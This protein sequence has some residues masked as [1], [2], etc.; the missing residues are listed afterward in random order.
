MT[1]MNRQVRR[2]LARTAAPDL[3]AVVA[4]AYQLLRAGQCQAAISAF[5][6]LLRNNA[7]KV[8][9]AEAHRGLGTAARRQRDERSAASHFRKSVTAVPGYAAAWLDLGVSFAVLGD[10]K[11]AEAAFARAAA[12]APEMG[13]AQR[14]LAAI[15]SQAVDVA[16]I[17]ALAVRAADPAT[18]EDERI[19]MLFALGRYADAQGEYDTAFRHFSDANI[20]LRTVQARLGINFDRTRL[21][22]DI[23]RIVAAFPTDGFKF[24]GDESEVPVFMLGMPRAGS[25]LFEQIAASHSRVRGAGEHDAIGAAAAQRGWGPNPAWTAKSLSQAARSYLAG[26]PVQADRVIDKMPDNIFQ[27]GL[28]ASL[29]PNARVVFCARDARDVAL[30][31]YFQ[32]FTQP[33]GF[34]TNLEDCAFRIAQVERLTTHW[35][36]VLPLRHMVMSY[37]ALLDAPVQESR[38]LIEFLG[39]DWEPACLEFY[40]TDRAVR[41]ASWAQVRQPLYSTAAGRWRHYAAHLPQLIEKSIQTTP[42]ELPRLRHSPAYP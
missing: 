22:S 19:E 12:L 36:Q 6:Q 37:E 34:D 4:H 16:E 33:Y 5:T 14:Y 27:L 21:A 35:C 23:D 11:G 8:A 29:F 15:R 42:A 30:S 39:L 40:K 28:I 25:S 38:R 20:L 26:L 1:T 10:L 17:T 9:Q 41:T 2:K 18:A 7:G 24:R 32:R 3:A 31:C 13:D